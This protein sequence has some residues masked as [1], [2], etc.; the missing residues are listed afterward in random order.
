MPGAWTENVGTNLIGIRS[1]NSLRR[2]IKSS[3]NRIWFVTKILANDFF[4]ITDTLSL[5]THGSV[6]RTVLDYAAKALKGSGTITIGDCPIQGTKWDQ[7]VKL[8]G[9]DQ[10]VDYAKASYPGIQFILRDYRL[11]RAVTS[12]G[13]RNPASR[14]ESAKHRIPGA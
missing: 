9:L 13:K 5:V 12:D 10:L 7:V 14:D 3:L 11:A 1:V 6:I 8:V 2:E 4:G